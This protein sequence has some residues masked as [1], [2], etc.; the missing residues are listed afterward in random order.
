M[1]DETALEVGTLV[2]DTRTARL[3][4]VMAAQNGRLYL[5]AVSG[6]REWEAEPEEVRR[7]DANEEL[8][9][10]VAEANAAGRWGR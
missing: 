5:R 6:G 10:R 1:R 3:G 9:A 2:L 8:R 7:A 4:R